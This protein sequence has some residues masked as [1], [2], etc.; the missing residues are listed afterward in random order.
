VRVRQQAFTHVI[1]ELLIARAKMDQSVQFARETAV[2]VRG[3]VILQYYM[4]TIHK[5]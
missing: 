5:P 3:H 1:F 4:R 2:D